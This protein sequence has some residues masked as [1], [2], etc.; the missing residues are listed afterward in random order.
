D[1]AYMPALYAKAHALR[2]YGSPDAALDELG[3][4]IDASSAA[5]MCLEERLHLRRDRGDCKGMEEDARAW[6][7]VEPDT[8]S[9]SYQIAA[10]LMARKEPI[11]SVEAALRRAWAALPKDERATNEAEDT[12][13]LALAQGD[14]VAAERATADW[15]AARVSNADVAL[16]SGPQQQLALI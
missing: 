1:A 14:F 13:N 3:K 8:Y 5:A 6:Q 15:D 11:Q 12:A 7:S 10:A 16:H 9:P 2:M 4:C